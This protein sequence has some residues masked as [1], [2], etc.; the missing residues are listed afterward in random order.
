[1]TAASA[2]DQLAEAVNLS[3]NLELVH[4]VLHH[5]LPE[6]EPLAT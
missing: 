6:Q 2:S 1:M 3:L 4:L 5:V